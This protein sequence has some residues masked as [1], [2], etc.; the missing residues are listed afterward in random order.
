MSGYGNRLQVGAPD[1]E[2]QTSPILDDV[3][4]EG[5]STDVD[6]GAGCCFFNDS[7]FAL[8]AFV[9]SGNE[10]LRCEGLGVWIREGSCSETG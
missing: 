8:G 2:L 9:C 1:P 5:Y 4:L 6:E 3:D 7:S 10:L